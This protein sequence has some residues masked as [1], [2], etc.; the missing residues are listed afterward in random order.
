MDYSQLPNDPDHP[1]GTSP[2]QSSPQTPSRTSY[3]SQGGNS[4]PSSPE[5][6]QSPY[7][8]EGQQASQ[9][10]D[11]DQET[12][13]STNGRYHRLQAGSAPTQNGHSPDLSERLQSPPLTEQGFIGHQYEQQHQPQPQRQP[14]YQQPQRATGPNR[15]QSGN[16]A[17]QRQ[18]LPQY[19]LHAKITGLERTGKKDL[20]LRFDVHVR[21]L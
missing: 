6:A 5:T 17:A 12:L 15:Y 9:N 4:V 16:R 20:I 10:D 13:V 14:S 21:W 11:S 19:K 3:N 18:N 7:A 8:S 1:A 2:W